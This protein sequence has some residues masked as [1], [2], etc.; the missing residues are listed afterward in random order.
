MYALVKVFDK[1]GR[2][3]IV[4]GDTRWNLL[5]SYHAKG[6]SGEGL[7]VRGFSGQ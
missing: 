6:A 5:V 3:T 2:G 4:K 1:A 7:F